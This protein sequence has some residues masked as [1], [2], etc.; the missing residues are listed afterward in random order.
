MFGL[1]IP[2]LI[3]IALVVI[4]VFGAGRLPE[5]GEGFGK[6]LSGFRKGLRESNDPPPFT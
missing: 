5:A 2:E 4:F 3:I 6:A 1:G